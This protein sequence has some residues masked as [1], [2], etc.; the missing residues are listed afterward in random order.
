L[1]TASS[2]VLVLFG[3]GACTCK[4]EASSLTPAAT[5]K[6]DVHS[7]EEAHEHLPTQVELP[8]EAVISAGIQTAQVGRARLAATLKLPGEVTAEP[9]RTASVSSA[10]PGRIER[11]TFNEGD[12]VQKGQPLA[13]LRVPD[14]GR[15]R[16]SLAAAKAKAHASS[17]NAQRLRTLK[18]DG[19]GSEQAI[20][21]AEAEAHAQE[22]EAQSLSQ[23]LDAI[24]V[25]ALTGSGYLM[26][27]RAPI[28]GVVISRHAIAGQPI[29]PE[30]AIAVIVDLSTV[31]FLAKVFEKDL[32]RLTTGARCEVELNAFPDKRFEGTVEYIGQQTDAVSRT[33]AAR[34]RLRNPDSLL[35]L[36][37]FGTATVEIPLPPQATEQIVIPR[38]AVTDI[39][40]KSVVFV[41]AEDGHFVVHQ[42]SLGESAL[43]QVQV[44]SGLSDGEEVVTQGVFTLKSLI[45]KSTLSE[46]EH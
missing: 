44:L 4:Q 11:V 46:E 13:T 5:G 31:W 45:L 1:K 20:V 39:A 15:L 23:Q 14:I 33:L 16:G 12:F 42:V 25:N 7:D 36:G 38:S 37:L 26:T 10:T 29:G 22:A 21:D 41:K 30:Q 43:A 8:L 32:N 24:G 34:I 9:D 17:L 40:G 3:F 2:L 28:S 19:L 27:L 35:R 18:A 6:A